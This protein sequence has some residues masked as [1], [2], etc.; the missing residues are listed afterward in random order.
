MKKI[1]VV[2]PSYNHSNYIEACLD[3][4]YFQDYPDIEIIIVDDNSQ[5]NSSE[6][7]SNWIS[8]TE[9]AEASFA[10]RYN[11]EKD[12]IKRVYHKRYNRLNRT[13]IFEKNKENLG[14]T[15]SYNK[16]F[17]LATGEYCTF[18]VS[19]DIAHP[20]MLSTL[21][22]PL[23]NDEADF[24]Y[25]D[26]FIIDDQHRIL[27]EFTL[28][29][30]SFQKSFCDWYLCGVATLYRRALHLRHGFYDETALADDH[31]CYLRFAMNGARFQHIPMTLYSVRS[32]DNREVGLHSQERFTALLNHSKKLTLKARR[33]HEDNNR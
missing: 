10:S 31:E 4:V 9:N 7:I 8:R 3:S 15:A 6:V 30:Y 26:M 24:T 19:D 33:W 23:D 28:P 20:Q 21:A 2:I 13:I 16:G 17:K 11:E 18:I 1:S 5:D 27:R 25:C 32:H 12:E 22:I 29:D 14:S